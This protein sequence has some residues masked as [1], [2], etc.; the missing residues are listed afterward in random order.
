VQ[1]CSAPTGGVAR[2]AML[3]VPVD[4]VR[5]CWLPCSS[6]VPTSR[7]PAVVGACGTH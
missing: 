2:A 4:R 7:L 1:T 6:D 5:E 3:F